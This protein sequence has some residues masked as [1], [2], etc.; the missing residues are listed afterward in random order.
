[1]SKAA[2][3][4]KLTEKEYRDALVSEEIDVG[5]PMQLREMRES[6]GW[7]QTDVAE[8]IGTAQPRFSVMEKPGYGNFSLT[9]L[10]KIA[11]VFDVAL[12][13]SFVPYGEFM[14]FKESISRKR[15]TAP[16]FCEEYIKLE[17][18]YSRHASS[19]RTT[20]D[21]VQHSFDFSAD[22][23]S[24]ASAYKPAAYTQ[25]GVS[26]VPEATVT[27]ELVKSAYWAYVVTKEGDCDVRA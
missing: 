11:S 20:T 22:T 3:L 16:G 9:T 18:R 17:K 27:P 21:T 2:L 24:V 7:T 26:H 1:M 23:S 15:L 12:I 13:V 25:A 6:R 19:T 4:E 14:D 5:L 8:Q 10:K